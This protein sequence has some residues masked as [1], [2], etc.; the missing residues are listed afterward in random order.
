MDTRELIIKAMGANTLNNEQLSAKALV[1]IA[2]IDRLMKND[3]QASI[4]ALE[5]VLKSLGY[6]LTAVES[7][8]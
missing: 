7:K 4:Y 1:N 3:N 5:R 2:A 8:Q 6:Q